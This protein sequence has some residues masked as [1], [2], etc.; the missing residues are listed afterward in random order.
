[1]SYAVICPVC[2]GHGKVPKDDAE[3][4][5]WIDGDKK[6]PPKDPRP[7]HGCPNGR[8]W[9]EVGYYWYTVPCLSG[10]SRFIVPTTN[11]D[12]PDNTS[13]FT[14]H[15]K[16]NFRIYPTGHTMPPPGEQG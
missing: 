6:V 13:P 7:C 15:I 5:A 4:K 14:V 1:V 2:G 12:T 9:V 3:L 8:G 11:D 16:H 10:F